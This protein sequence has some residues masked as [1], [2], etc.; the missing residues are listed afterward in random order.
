MYFNSKDIKRTLFPEL[1]I[2]KTSFV[3]VSCLL[4]YWLPYLRLILRFLNAIYMRC[5]SLVGFQPLNTT[6][7]HLFKHFHIW[8]HQQYLAGALFVSEYLNSSI[9]SF[10][11][12][13]MHL[14][15]L[16][17]CS[18]TSKYTKHTLLVCLW[19][20]KAS[21]LPLMLW[22][23]LEKHAPFLFSSHKIFKCVRQTLIH[24]FLPLK[25]SR[26][27]GLLYL[28]LEKRHSHFVF[29]FLITVDLFYCLFSGF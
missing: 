2:P 18:L 10:F 21:R 6:L 14:P 25:T 22:F 16:S 4:I 7:F 3:L 28:N 20:L 26:V 8:K 9:F 15:H 29:S 1:Q 24:P 23:G 19:P 11:N 17:W 12:M 27:H 5:G 13:Q